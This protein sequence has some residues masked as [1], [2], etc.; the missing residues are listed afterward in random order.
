MVTLITQSQSEFAIH[1]RAVLGLPLGFKF[2]GAGASGAYKARSDSHN[3]KISVPDG[4]FGENSFVR[5]FSKPDSHIG[6]RMGVALVL[7]DDVEKAKAQALEI[8]QSM[9]D[10]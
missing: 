2:Y 8:A 5:I 3:P 4:A 7:N 1:V 9:S 6:R 10:S